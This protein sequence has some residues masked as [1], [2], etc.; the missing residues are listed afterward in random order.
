MPIIQMIC[1]ANSR[2]LSGR[3]VA[4]I[5]ISGFVRGW[6]RPVSALVHGELTHEFLYG[7]PPREVKLLDVIELSVLQ[8]RR[9]G[10]HSEDF[11]VDSTVPWKVIGS[12]SLS[13]AAGFAENHPP[14]LWVNGNHTSNGFNDQIAES[15]AAALPNSLRLIAPK[16]LY[17][18][19]EIDARNGHMR[20]RGEFRLEEQRYLLWITDPRIEREF[21]RKPPESHRL[22]K[23]PLLCISIGEVFDKTGS[24]YKLIAGVIESTSP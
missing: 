8:P 6:I 24:C 23:E 15:E 16:H 3:C 9:L 1:F 10:C 22:V 4:G 13:E 14:I 21:S 12:I 2:K 7:S 18:R 20:V 17:I 5:A 11:V 19:S